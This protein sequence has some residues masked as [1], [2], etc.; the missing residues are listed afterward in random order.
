M[1]LSL[2]FSLLGICL[3]G[4]MS[5]GP[6]LVVVL[7]NTL[8]GGH[9]AGLACAVAHGFAVACYAAVTVAGLAMLI[10]RSPLLFIGLQLSGAVYLVYLGVNGLRNRRTASPTAPATPTGGSVNTTPRQMVSA[11]ISGF[12]VA[13]LNPKLAI[14]MLALLSQ[15]L[16]DELDRL[17]LVLVVLAVGLTDAIWYALVAALISR[18]PLMR[19]FQRSTVVVN[20]LFGALLSALGVGMVVNLMIGAG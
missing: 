8:A 15:F 1:S 16:P 14:F 4:A 5:P 18:P 13:F 2:W 20:T 19:R 11:A 10:A 3:L 17:T 9:R 12:L 6:S 7:R